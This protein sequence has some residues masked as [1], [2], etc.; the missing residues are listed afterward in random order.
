MIDIDRMQAEYHTFIAEIF[1]RLD[2]IS[3]SLAEIKSAT[4]HLD[5]WKNCDFCWFQIRKICE[6][7][8]LAVVLAHHRD[9]GLIEDLSKWRPK[10]LLA[11][12]AKLSD[13]PTPIQISNEIIETGNGERQLAPVTQPIK[14]ALISEIY[15]RCSNLLHVGSLERILESNMPAYDLAHLEIWLEGFERLL[16]NHILMLPQIERILVCLHTKGS[17]AQPQIFLMEDKGQG[18]FVRD[19]LPEFALLAK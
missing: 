5:C 8:A 7:I 15:G 19:N 18:I 13:H 6:Y 4:N 10:D 9:N 14:I 16:R 2:A 1:R 17:E 11:Q 3:E 12:A